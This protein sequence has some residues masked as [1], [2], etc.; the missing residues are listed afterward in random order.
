MR[1]LPKISLLLAA[2][3]L[4]LHFHIQAQEF[5]MI[6]N[7]P[8]EEDIEIYCHD[9]G[10][11]EKLYFIV[12]DGESKMLYGS[13]GTAASTS[14][15]Q[16]VSAYLGSS[17]LWRM[18]ILNS[19]LYFS[20]YDDVNGKD[21][22]KTDGTVAGTE[23]VYAFEQEG[24]YISASNPI[25]VFDN[26]I[27]FRN[28]SEQDSELWVS[29][30][31]TAGTQEFD[32][33]AFEGGS[34]PEN[35]Y[36]FNGK[37]YFNADGGSSGAEL[38]VTDGTLDGTEMLVNINSSGDSDPA[39]GVVLNDILIFKAN[40]GIHGFELW[41]TDGTASGTELITD[42][43][44]EFDTFSEFGNLPGMV[45]NDNYFFSP[46][47]SYSQVNNSSLWK[48]DGTENGTI[49]VKDFSSAIGQEVVNFKIAYNGSLCFIANDGDSGVEP[50]LTDGS[51]NGTFMLKDINTT[52]DSDPDEFTEYL[53]YLYFTCD[54]GSNGFEIWKTDGTTSGTNL[55]MD[56]NPLGSSNPSHLTVYNG[57]LYFFAT[58]GSGDRQLWRTNGTTDGTEVL[59][60]EVATNSSPIPWSSAP[61][62][63]NQELFVHN[64]ALYLVASFTEEGKE[65][66]KF[67]TPTNI[68]EK[69]G[70][71]SGI[72]VYPNPAGS[73]INVALDRDQQSSLDLIVFDGKG[74]V[75]HET[76]ISS[77]K[78]RVDISKLK[79]G[80]YI[81]QVQ[82]GNEMIGRET[83]VKQ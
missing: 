48:T 1:Q 64:G 59:S 32:L 76:Q 68:N 63:D 16:E 77:A 58:D 61:L 73:T 70:I 42:I 31:T 24:S 33:T 71:N 45:L 3:I 38:W 17:L 69:D 9:F 78:T 23:L 21:L 65:L 7:I 60:P 66:W 8:A 47:S 36:E 13:D 19:N 81:L 50:W 51:E 15:L 34:S 67:T 83:F 5:E 55:F 39:L 12:D 53:G 72:S 18:A 29:D 11:S 62:E 52:G 6:S 75:V 4:S 20:G 43:N 74:R 30:G 82:R 14:P 57:L 10:N 40:D 28:Y 56:I 25:T 49:M 46:S 2:L 41:K 35:F 22:W 80:L 44:P 27:F 37:L 26:K 79:T 54:D